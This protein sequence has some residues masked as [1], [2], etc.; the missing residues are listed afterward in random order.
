MKAILFANTDWYLH[1]FRAPLAHSLRQRGWEVVFVSPP[2]PYTAQLQTNGCR[3]RELPM[4]RRSLNPLR[5]WA[6]VRRLAALYREEQPDLVHHFTIKSV[7]YGSLAARQ[8]RVPAVVNAVT[9]LGHVFS[10]TG[11][12]SRLLRPLVKTLLRYALSGAQSRLIVQNPD[13]Y[14]AFAA[15]GL[16]PPARLRLIKSSGVNTTRFQPSART[17][18]ERL[19]VLL[20]TRLLWDKGIGEYVHAARECRRQGLTADFL[21]AGAPDPGNPGSVTAAQV[22][23][24]Q[25]EGVLTALGHV[26]DMAQLLTTVDL[27]VLPSYYGEGVPR[28]LIEAAAAGLPIIT[29]DQPGCREAVTHAVNGLQ[30]PPRDAA[31]FTRAVIDLLSD[32]ARRQAFAAASRAKALAEFDEQHV[33]R[34]TY[35]VYQELLPLPPWESVPCAELSV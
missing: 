33:L 4:Q 18:R 9:G 30:V 1:N 13:D 12:R 32:S 16:V 23:A 22:A 35:T 6:L 21:L 17:G 5:E 24:W 11:L 31:A 3:W 25:A 14:A 28:S 15:P 34:D 20:A 10:N 27:M 8:A 26:D 2:G 7:V 29:T 19:R